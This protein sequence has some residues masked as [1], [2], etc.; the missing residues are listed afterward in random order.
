[1]LRPNHVSLTNTSS[2][3]LRTSLLFCCFCL[4]LINPMQAIQANATSLKDTI[5]TVHEEREAVQ[6]SVFQLIQR[7]D[8]ASVTLKTNVKDLLE[9]KKAD[10]YQ[11][12]TFSFEGTDGKTY[13]K[14][15]KVKARGKSR[16]KIC[17][18]PPLKLKFSKE[19]LN[20][21][22]LAAD[23]NKLKLVTHCGSSRLSQ[24]NILKEFLAYHM[25]NELT[26]NSFRVKLIKVIYEDTE[27]KFDAIEKYG[28]IIESND[29][30]ATRI[31][32]EITERYNLPEEDLDTDLY[33]LHSIF[34]YMIGNTDW[35]L[36]I[37]HNLK[38]VQN[39]KEGKAKIVP[40]DFDFSGLV[41]AKYASP[42]PDYRD[43]IFS[44]KDRLYLGLCNN[45]EELTETLALF[46]SKEKK[47]LKLVADFELLSGKDRKNIARF[48]KGFYKTINDEKKVK[49]VFRVGCEEEE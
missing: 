48:I 39:G 4:L 45:P 6:T 26:E 9:N 15:I 10:K 24:Q 49:E 20:S 17:D 22:G 2:S 13:T 33:R 18:F 27:N 3:F 5:I 29:E 36:S 47:I 16:R 30:L 32:G 14:T 7:E 40:Y 34:Q 25:Y 41:G 46:K 44:T 12:A 8:Y 11:E 37:M 43:T 19:D 31:G 21:S 42:H 1:M 35:R 23:F 28:F 38:I